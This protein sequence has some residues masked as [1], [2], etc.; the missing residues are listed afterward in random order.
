MTLCPKCRKQELEGNEER[1]P[2]CA[3]EQDSWV[4]K[5]ATG[6]GVLVLAVAAAFFRGGRGGDSA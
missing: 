1:C 3:N 5:A 2:R 6:V 4:V